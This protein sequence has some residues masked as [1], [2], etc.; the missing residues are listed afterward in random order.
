MQAK[1]LE[2]VEEVATV[3]REGASGDVEVLSVGGD[4]G[5]GFGKNLTVDGDEWVG[6][7]GKGGEETDCRGQVASE[8]HRF[9]G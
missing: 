7:Q 6:K 5:V 9:L 1:F 3:S 2:T 4:V 8:W